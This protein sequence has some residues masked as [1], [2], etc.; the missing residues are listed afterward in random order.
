MKRS[1]SRSISM[2]FCGDE[3]EDGCGL[4]PPTGPS[5]T[6]SIMYSIIRFDISSWVQAQPL[7]RGMNSPSNTWLNGPWP[8]SWHSPAMRCGVR[9]GGVG[10]QRDAEGASTHH[11]LRVPFSY[12]KRWLKHAEP[13]DHAAGEVAHACSGVAAWLRFNLICSLWHAPRTE[14]VLEP[15]VA[16]PWEHKIRASKLL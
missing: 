9:G 10:D 8:M 5:R 13:V 14:T 16:A 2:W 15:V 6:S 1:S 3:R 12:F 11:Q 7:A 4:W